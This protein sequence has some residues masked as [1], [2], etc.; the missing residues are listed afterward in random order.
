MVNRSSIRIWFGVKLVEGDGGGFVLGD[1]DVFYRVIYSTA[2]VYEAGVACVGAADNGDAVLDS[3]EYRRGSVLVRRPA[4]AIPGI[5]GY[6]YE[7]LSSVLDKAPGN[8][9]KDIF[10]ANQSR[11][12][13]FVGEG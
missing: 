8:L 13:N 7:K 1:K 12:L 9:R 11:K 3:P 5:I 6:N 10:E 2:G 4:F